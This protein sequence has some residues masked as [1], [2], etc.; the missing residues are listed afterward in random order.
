M[1]T[2]ADQLRPFFEALLGRPP[3]L[4]VR[5]W[6]GSQVGDADPP[7]PAVVHSPLALRRILYAPG[8]VGFVRAY[9][10]GDIALDGALHA[11]LRLARPPP[12]Q[13]WLR[14]NPHVRTT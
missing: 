11:A 12:P 1:V 8:A 13:Q 4:A 7:A 9:T 2:A 10:F 3:K 6:D 14:A 5:L